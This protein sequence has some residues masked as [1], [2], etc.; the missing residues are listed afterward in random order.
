[1]IFTKIWLEANKEAAIHGGEFVR[2]MR[3]ALEKKEKIQVV[4][5][6]NFLQKDSDNY[7]A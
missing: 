3:E 6:T 4:S 1:M 2:K 5:P 7:L